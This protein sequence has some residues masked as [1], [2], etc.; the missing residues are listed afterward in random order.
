MGLCL[1][2]PGLSASLQRIQKKV[3]CGFVS[4]SSPPCLWCTEVWKSPT[5]KRSWET[6]EW[7]LLLLETKKRGTLR[8]KLQIVKTNATNLFSSKVNFPIYWIEWLWRWIYLSV[9]HFIYF[10]HLTGGLRLFYTPQ[11]QYLKAVSPPF[12]PR[13]L[14]VSQY[15]IQ[16]LPCP[17]NCQS[18]GFSFLSFKETQILLLIQSKQ[19]L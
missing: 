13:I 2:W 19:C 11:Y 17:S 15:F 18:V 9:F 8:W 3:L 5:R 4:L 10:G 6:A 7:S 1:A 14:N 12:C 16:K